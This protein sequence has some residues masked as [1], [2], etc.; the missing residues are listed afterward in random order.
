MKKQLV[1][2]VWLPTK[3]KKAENGCHLSFCSTKLASSSAFFWTNEPGTG[4]HLSLH[5]S[6]F[7]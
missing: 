4:S 3:T 6:E 1:C 5:Q 7:L 2:W